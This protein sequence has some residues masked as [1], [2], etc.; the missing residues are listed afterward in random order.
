MVFGVRF[1]PGQ[2]SNAEDTVTGAKI[3][4][5]AKAKRELTAKYESEVAKVKKLQFEKSE[6]ERRLAHSES[7]VVDI[8][9]RD[10]EL[11]SNRRLL[12]SKRSPDKK[13]EP[14]QS[15][16]EVRQLTQKL[17]S[18]IEKA[19]LASHE[20]TCLKQQLQKV[21]KLLEREVGLG[22]DVSALLKEDTPGY[23][24]RDQ[25]IQLLKSKVKFLL[26]TGFQSNL[27]RYSD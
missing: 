21:Q 10:Q 6:L 4:E 16:P 24:G 13:L 15:D 9:S 5:L 26:K 20:N 19:S 14:C 17:H 12:S 2:S 11:N 3:V 18:A 27:E 8:V 22:V 7:N 25:Q 23:R 1:I